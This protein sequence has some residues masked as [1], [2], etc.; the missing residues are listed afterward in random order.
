[1]SNEEIVK[2]DDS[3]L[4]MV[5]GGVSQDKQQ[6]VDKYIKRWKNFGFS[7]TTAEILA[8][9]Y[10]KYCKEENRTEW[11]QEEYQYMIQNWNNV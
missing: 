3:N 7:L 11:T 5:I 1:M 10:I 9:S 8:K 4:E 6:F 2:L